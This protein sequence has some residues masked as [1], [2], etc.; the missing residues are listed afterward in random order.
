MNILYKFKYLLFIIFLLLSMNANAEYTAK[1]FIDGLSLSN[2]E[3]SGG[4]SA[5]EDGDPTDQNGGVVGELT[6]TVSRTSGYN[7]NEFILTI[8][9]N[10]YNCFSLSNSFTGDV[11][12]CDNESNHRETLWFDTAQPGVYTFI[13]EGKNS[14]GGTPEVSYNFNIEILPID[15][16]DSSDSELSFGYHRKVID[17]GGIF[18][19]NINSSTFDCFQINILNEGYGSWESNCFNGVLPYATT[20]DLSNALPDFNGILNLEIVGYN[21]DQ[22]TWEESDHKNYPFSVTVNEGSQMPV[23][24]DFDLEFGYPSEYI[25]YTSPIYG[26]SRGIN[27]YFIFFAGKSRE[28]KLDIPSI[29][30]TTGWLNIRSYSSSISQYD[31]GDPIIAPFGGNHDVIVTVR[32]GQN[33]DT[34]T[35]N[36]YLGATGIGNINFSL[37]NS[38]TSNC[39]GQSM[40]ISAGG[41]GDAASITFSA[42]NTDCITIQSNDDPDYNIAQNK[43]T[44]TNGV[45]IFVDRYAVFFVN[46][47]NHDPIGQSSKVYNY[48]YSAISNQ[49]GEVVNGVL[50]VT[51]YYD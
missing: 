23:I 30:Y 49:S 7:H 33:I 6:Y 3:N 44:Y 46:Y 28:Y 43:C 10:N 35:K 41:I 25:T 12:S 17:Q 27:N 1:I 38:D 40:A 19:V 34:M 29:G 51:I 15:S 36:I 14:A 39:Y 31:V 37:C 32:N 2:S 20:I 9:S 26:D 21:I 13:L 18:S 4:N 5:E 11:E 45:D 16:E 24:S 8:T 50:P 42:D 48:N 22:N 47:P